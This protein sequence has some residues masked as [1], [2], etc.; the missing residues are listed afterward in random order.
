MAEKDIIAGLNSIAAK[1]GYGKNGN[2]AFS[3]DEWN[4]IERAK[5]I[6]REYETQNKHFA[7]R[8]AEVAEKAFLILWKECKEKAEICEDCQTSEAIEKYVHENERL[9]AEN[10]E[11]RARLNKAVE[12]PRIIH[13]NPVEWHIQYQYESGIITEDIRFSE[14]AAEARLKELKEEI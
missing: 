8:R 7:E 1:Y 14:A 6:I 10:A 12:L 4:T 13:P 5:E 11:L 2:E 9:Q 3:N